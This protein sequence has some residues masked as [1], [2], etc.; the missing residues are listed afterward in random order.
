MTRM[1]KSIDKTWN[2]F[3][4]CR[5]ECS[6]CNARKAAETRFRHISRYRNGFVPHLVAKEFERRFRPGQFI[7]VAYMGDIAFATME[8][9][10]R[11][12]ARIRQFPETHFLIQTKNP[13]QLFDWR[14]DWGITLPPNVYIGTTIET[15]RDYWLTKAPPPIERFR[16]LAGYPHNFKFL[17]IEP[18]MDFDLEELSQWVKL[19]Q[20]NIVEV[21]ADNYHNHLPEPP[22]AK[23][24]ALLEALRE[25]SC[26]VVE[27]PGLER[28]KRLRERN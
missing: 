18:I 26:T 9:F 2:V 6:Y 24:E 8:Q 28:L 11:I 5:H 15:N 16:Y 17:S 12:L 13:K 25:I 1:F 3:V 23:V 20:L 22:W 19:I 10:L 4:G 14:E 7:F 27:K 21:G